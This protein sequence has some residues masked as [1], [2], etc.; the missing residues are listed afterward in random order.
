MRS[1]S[2]SVL[3]YTSLHPSPPTKLTLDRP[4]GYRETSRLFD[5]VLHE[6]YSSSCA[7]VDA[8]SVVKAT[9]NLQSFCEKKGHRKTLFSSLLIFSNINRNGRPKKVEH[10]NIFRV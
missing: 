5:I 4:S 7:L 9:E 3:I 1:C 8:I 6:S 10:Q 2:N